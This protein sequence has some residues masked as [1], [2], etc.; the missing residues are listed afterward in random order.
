[1]LNLVFFNI[2]LIYLLYKSGLFA[3][4][5]NKP[6][7][8]NVEINSK[9]KIHTENIPRAGGLLLLIFLSNFIY[10]NKFNYFNLDLILCLIP[11]FIIGLF[12]DIFK[13]LNPRLRIVMM[14]ISGCFFIYLFETNYYLPIINFNYLDIFNN[15]IVLKIL[16][17]NFCFLVLLNGL[18][19]VDGLN[20]LLIIT[21]LSILLSINI[22]FDNQMFPY[23][24]LVN[25]FIYSLLII[26]LFNFPTARIFMGDL[27]AYIIG[28]FLCL[29][30]L[31][32]FSQNPN[33]RS[34]VASIIFFYPIFEVLF[35]ILRKLYLSKNP[36]MPDKS[37]L[38]T[39]LFF[40]VKKRLNNSSFSNAIST[41]FITPLVFYPTILIYFLDLHNTHDILLALISCILLYSTCYY[42]I[43]K[44]TRNFVNNYLD[45]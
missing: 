36:F 37:H 31:I 35:S 4:L 33:I 15:S 20:G 14:F 38:H 40:Y 12:E 26:F 21:S 39:L 11:F 29:Y 5:T 3:K 42:L 19:F 44:K 6:F 23:S 9:H 41:L 7:L 22:I 10:L 1:M 32:L 17:F 24:Y 13:S 16:F 18:N 45:I 34:E 8:L 27:G 43:N 28:I 2:F 30:T 25:S